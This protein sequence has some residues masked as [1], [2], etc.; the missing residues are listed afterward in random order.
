MQVTEHQKLLREKIMHLSGKAGI[1]HLQKALSDTRKKFLKS[2]ENRTPVE[3]PVPHMP[4]P[5]LMTSPSIAGPDEKSNSVSSPFEDDANMPPLKDLDSSVSS[6]SSLVDHPGEIMSMDNV[7]IVN[8]FLH[9]R[10]YSATDS[11]HITDE[12]QKVVQVGCKYEHPLFAFLYFSLS[13][14]KIYVE[15]QTRACKINK[16]EAFNLAGHRYVRQWKKLSGMSSLI[17][18]KRKSMITLLF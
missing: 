3:S 10:H 5:R 14:P 6:S 4:S 18:Y 2:K 13:L 8:E 7:L 17:L 16:T 11:L 9:G 1:E 12:N 15:N